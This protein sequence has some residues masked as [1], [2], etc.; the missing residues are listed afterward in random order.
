M[1][2]NTL[3]TVEKEFTNH[4]NA[5]GKYR[6]PGTSTLSLENLKF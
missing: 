4:F 6:S 2:Q 1:P 5:Q 3:V